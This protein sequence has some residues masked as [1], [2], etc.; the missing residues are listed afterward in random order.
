ERKDLWGDEQI[1]VFGPYRMPINSLSRD[2]NLRH[3][4]GACKGDALRRE[5]AKGDVTDHPVLF[6]NLAGVEEASELLGLDFACYGRRQSYPK[7]LHTSALYA[8][9]CARPR[10]LSAMTVV[11]LRCRAIETDLYRYPFAWQ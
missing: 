3:Q 4:V 6:A 5:A 9:K 8:F 11:P 2:R 1:R 10:A 7:S